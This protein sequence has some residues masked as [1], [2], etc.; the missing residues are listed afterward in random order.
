V[1]PY[2]L[3]A[4]LERMLAVLLFRFGNEK[5]R[6]RVGGPGPTVSLNIRTASRGVQCTPPK[7]VVGA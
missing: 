6:G 3:L 2:G 5:E 1:D 7:T 4:L